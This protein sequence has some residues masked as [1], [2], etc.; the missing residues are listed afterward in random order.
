MLKNRRKKTSI[1]SKWQAYLFGLVEKGETYKQIA[2]QRGVTTSEVVLVLNKDAWR[3]PPYGFTA[4]VAQA[5]QELIDEG[6]PL[7]NLLEIL[8]I[9]LSDP[10]S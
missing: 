7:E 10:D 1:T 3:L 4:D 5:A 2:E 9:L 6:T 8:Y